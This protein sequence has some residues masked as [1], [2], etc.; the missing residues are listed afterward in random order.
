MK[1]INIIITTACNA[2]CE[3]CFEHTK[4]A[5]CGLQF[6]LAGLR[7]T[8]DFFFDKWRGEIISI[9]FFGG[10]PTLCE[11]NIIYTIE[12]AMSV[13]DKY[14]VNCSFLMYTNAFIYPT[15]LVEY[16]N[17]N[18]IKFSMQISNEGFDNT[19]KDKGNLIL[20]EKIQS[21][22][23]QYVKDKIMFIVR[24]TMSSNNLTT[25]ENLRDTVKLMY[26]TGV[27]SF[28]Y[29]PIMEFEWTEEH[30]KIWEDGF[31]L[32]TDYL[33]EIYREDPIAEFS[34]QNYVHDINDIMP[35]ICGAGLDY[36]TVYPD[37][38]VYVCQRHIPISTAG[39]E[40]IGSIYTD[41]EFKHMGNLDAHEDCK[42]CPVKNC[43]ICPIVSYKEVNGRLTIPK[44]K[45]CNIRLI[46]WNCYMTF[47]E[48]MKSAHLY[49]EPTQ[50][51][52]ESLE[53]LSDML[54][55]LYG[56]FAIISHNSTMDHFF[57][58]RLT[59]EDNVI[60][61]LHTLLNELKFKFNLKYTFDYTIQ[62]KS[63]ILHTLTNLL[64]SLL[65]K[66]LNIDNKGYI[67]NYNDSILRSY[68]LSEIL[69]E[70]MRNGN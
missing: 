3:F 16:V 38:N 69:I 22:I 43:K 58:P 32:I 27:Q 13:K 25:A 40:P 5:A 48:K 50:E 26:E 53:V 19:S 70:E 46:Y 1:T 56:A 21:N 14:K 45:Y 15:K 65:C 67:D 47:I 60:Q 57:N 35:R 68:L 33:L 10:E 30:Y 39:V 37:G 64:E 44:T 36:V 29:F 66:T 62:D 41:V 24:A 34:F 7:K 8:I 4:Q 12:Y 17:T 9:D 54:V 55:N 6:D 42:V 18:S 51:Q 63:I 61:K 59:F 52:K 49:F 28:Y 31:T 11:D 23:N 2:N 20:R